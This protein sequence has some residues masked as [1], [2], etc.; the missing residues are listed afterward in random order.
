LASSALVAMIMV[1]CLAKAQTDQAKADSATSPGEIVVRGRRLPARSTLE[2]TVYST[3]DNAQ[4]VAGSAADVLNTVPSVNIA[5]DG[6]VTVRGDGNVQIFV[7]G[8]PSA[9]LNGPNRAMALEALSGGSI[10]SVELLTNPSVRHDANGGVIL[11]IVL[12]KARDQ[13]L[14]GRITAN[15]GDQ[16]RRNLSGNTSIR[17]GRIRASIEVALR[18]DVRLPE[19]WDD[20]RLLDPEGGVTNRFTT[21]ARYTPTRSRS[22]NLNGALAFAVTDT[23]EVGAEAAVSTG[24]PLNVVT[25][26]HRDF[27]RGDVLDSV[28]RRVRTGTY[29]NDARDFTLFYREAVSAKRPAL[30]I[31]AQHSKTGLRSDR[32]F[33]TTYQIPA[34][35]PEGQRVRYRDITRIDR[36]AADYD[37]PLGKRWKL[38]SGVEWKREKSQLA[39]GLAQFDPEQPT[40]LPVPALSQSDGVQRIGAIHAAATYREGNWAVEAG[41]RLEDVRMT[42]ATRPQ[43]SRVRRAMTGLVHRLSINR[44]FGRDHVAL[45]L[46]RTRQR[47]DPRDLSQVVVTVDPQNLTSGN[48]LL[49][50]QEVTAT[51]VEYGFSHSGFE[52]AATLYVRETTD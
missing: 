46:S 20:R 4:G 7:D 41:M 10:A 40:A 3:A 32:R 38:R 33:V 25:E 28:Y 23:A 16:G 45:R 49:R 8:R 26:D 48:P 21:L 24:E 5:P 39:N 18:E 52:A 30:S 12:K 17:S 31:E 29:V 50:P 13:G 9:A 1:P 6:R 27:L 36:I 51:E 44:D 35:L 47:Y 37:L 43:P 14:R 15:I 19:I 11:N 2:G 34:R 42:S 22:T